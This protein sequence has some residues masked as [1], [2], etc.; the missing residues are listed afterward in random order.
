MNNEFSSLTLGTW[1]FG[2]TSWG[3]ADDLESLRVIDA[4]I[5]HGVAYIDTAPIYSHG[6]SE[7]LIGKALQGK[8]GRI[9]IATK[10]GLKRAADGKTIVHDLSR[11]QILNEIEGS[12]R[13]LKTDYIDLYQCHAPDPEMDPGEV[14]GI[15][16]DLQKQGKIRYIG[17]SNFNPEQIKSFLDHGQILSCQDQ[18]SL[19]DRAIESE[20]LPFVIEQNISV[21]AYGPLSGG[22]LTGKYKT[23]PHFGNADCRSFFYDHYQGEAFDKAQVIVDKLSALNHPLNEL[24]LNWVRQ[25]V[26]VKSVIVGCR[27]VEQLEQNLKS[28]SWDLTSEELQSIQSIIDQ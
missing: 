19:L 14:M 20:L 26:G 27:T 5:E 25:Q 18:Y 16:L 8:R 9:K 15:L 21:L 1:V 22:I 28:L 23:T 24:A 4:A 11:S 10:C 6:D 12:L 3:G 13:R 7:R 2:G 17:V